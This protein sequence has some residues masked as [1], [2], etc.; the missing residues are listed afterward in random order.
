MTHPTPSAALPIGQIVQ[1]DSLEVLRGW[2]AAS[3]D[4]V[5]TDPPYGL[6]FMGKKWDAFPTNTGKCVTTG[7]LGGAAGNAGL[8][9]S[10]RNAEYGRFMQRVGRALFRVLKPGAHLLM[11]GAPRRFHWQGVAL[12]LAGFELR[13]T[14]CWLFGEGFPKSHNLHGEWEGWGT[15]LK[16]GWE[17]IL[18]A[19]KPFRGTV[20]ANVLAHGTGAIHVDACRP[21]TMEGVNRMQNIQTAA[22]S[23]YGGGLHGGRRAEPSFAG[24]WPANVVLDE[25]AAALLD[26][27]SGLL[28]SGIPSGV[29][30]GGQDNCYGRFEGGIPVTG[31]GDAGGAS[32]F[33]YRA[34]ARRAEREAGLREAMGGVGALRDGARS[35]SV[36]NDHPTVK[37]VDVMRWLIRM[38]TP[39]GG[40]V[41]DP[42]AGSGSTLC[43][44][45]VEGVSWLAVEQSAHYCD[46]ARA[47][48]AHWREVEAPIIRVKEAVRARQ[49]DLARAQTTLLGEGV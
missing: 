45:E 3:V 25:A 15:A 9:D 8:Y 28:T 30:A 27:Q 22:R 10:R 4:T 32:R 18:M 46:I 31:Y 17:P 43:A 2:P 5:V 42:F 6:H 41:L 49:A 29:K 39:P 23:G 16:P 12:E 21:T 11:F 19:R 20:A 13:D 1:G 44:A 24:R 47:R 34:K 37:P 7:G 26:A 14:L 48:A 38:V 35:I 40:V 36:A 33:F